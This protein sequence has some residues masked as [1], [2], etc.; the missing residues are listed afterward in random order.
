MRKT[1]AAIGIFDG[2]HLGHRKIIRAA[3]RAAKRN[4]GRSVVITFDPHPL[5][6]LRP[7][8]PIPSIMSTAHRVR[9]ICGLGAG[10]CSV[11]RFTRKFSHLKPR[12]FVRKILVGKFR[13]SQ[14][15][16]GADFVFGKDNAGDTALLKRLGREYGFKV[17]VVPMV[18][19]GGRIVSSTAI[20]NLIVTGKLKEAS[21]ML[22]RPVTVFGTVVSGSRRGRLLGYP[23]ANIDPHHEAIPPSGVYAV[24]VRFGSKRFAG[25]LF[26]G[27]RST[28]GEKEPVIEAH[29]FDFRSMIYG[30]DIEVTFVKRLRGVKK[31]ASRERLVEEIRKDD[32]KAR[33][34][35]SRER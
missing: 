10:A 31:F 19:A 11:I 30:E 17:T 33:R 21:R 9:L 35:L 27:P 22:G 7:H 32:A 12:D 16:V 29:I 6:V 5:K 4:R 24:R 15:F 3:V 2:V 8:K 14:L 23:T 25:A 28:F 1:V 13:V 18:K 34:I 20:R 26:I